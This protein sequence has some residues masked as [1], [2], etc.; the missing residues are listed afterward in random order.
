MADY[1]RFPTVLLRHDLPDGTHH[2]DWML[3]RDEHGPLLTFRVDRDFSLD[4]EP[5][6]AEPIG[7]HRRAYLEYQGS[8]SGGRGSVVRVAKG[9][10]STTLGGDGEVEVA[11]KIGKRTAKLRGIRQQNGRFL[12]AELKKEERT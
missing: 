3:A 12:F 9:R 8:I 11:M 7:D 2:F 6:E 1:E 10:C 5:F 4:S